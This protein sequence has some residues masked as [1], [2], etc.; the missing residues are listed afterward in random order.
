MSSYLTKQEQLM[1]QQL[2]KGNTKAFQQFVVHY[3][4]YV[5]TIVHRIVNQTED[6]EDVAQEVFVKAYKYI[7][8]FDGKSKLS[9]WLYRIAVNTAISH[10]RK[11]KYHTTELTD[12]H[13]QSTVKQENRVKTEEQKKYIQQ[14]FALLS[15]DDVT[16]LTLFYLKELSLKEIADVIQLEQNNVKV[17]LYRA[18][19]RL[20]DKLK[21]ILKQEVKTIL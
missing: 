16:L 2:L 5:F 18:R 21:F 13:Q 10:R 4:D 20:A 7:K 14:A 19:K 11:K 1:I 6:A 9:T 17:K 15:E 12:A 3:Q 8:N